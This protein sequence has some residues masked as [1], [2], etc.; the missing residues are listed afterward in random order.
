LSVVSPSTFQAPWNQEQA[1]TQ[2]PALVVGFSSLDI[3]PVVAA[4][5]EVHPISATDYAFDGVPQSVSKLSAVLD[6]T[7]RRKLTVDPP[8]ANFVVAF[9]TPTMRRGFSVVR[10]K[11]VA[12]L[13]TDCEIAHVELEITIPNTNSGQSF[14]GTTLGASLG[15]ANAD[16]DGDGSPDAWTVVLNGDAPAMHWAGY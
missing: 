4:L 14:G 7:N 10:A 2:V 15:A 12:E 1:T 6:M 3:A 13:S 9:G 11:V 16:T 5:G 8:A